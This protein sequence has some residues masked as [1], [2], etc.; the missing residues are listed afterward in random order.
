M[1]GWEQIE[2]QGVKKDL[3]Q[4]RK[5]AKVFDGGE[6]KLPWLIG[7]YNSTASSQSRRWGEAS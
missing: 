3:T 6:D 5:D 4:R 7:S 1:C 2:S